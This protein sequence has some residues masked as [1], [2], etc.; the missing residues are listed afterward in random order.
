MNELETIKAQL[1]DINNSRVRVQTLIDQAKKQ[2]EEIQQKY[3]VN[4]IEELK[5]LVEKAQSDYVNQL[6]LAKQYIEDT[7]Q[8]LSKF[9]GIM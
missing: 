3:G 6:G 7:K 2:C 9:N 8:A 1:N 4:S 5:E